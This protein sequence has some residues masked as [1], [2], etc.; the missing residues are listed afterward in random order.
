MKIPTRG[1]LERIIDLY[2]EE[3]EEAAAKY[4]EQ[5][6][7]RREDPKIEHSLIKAVL[8]ERTRQFEKWGE[9]N[10]SPAFWNLI[11]MEEVGEAAAEVFSG[12]EQDYFDEMVQVCAVALSM[13]ESFKRGN[14][15]QANLESSFISDLLS[16]TKVLGDICKLSFGKNNKYEIVEAFGE[17]ATIVEKSDLRA[18][19]YL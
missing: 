5:D 13:M 3:G 18:R 15:E 2:N 19:K 12:K 6:V 8:E 7:M 11:L 4:L 14:F 17:L 1:I 9:Q 10:H 16:I